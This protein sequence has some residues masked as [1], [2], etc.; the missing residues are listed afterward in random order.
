M[1]TQSEKASPLALRLP[2]T[3]GD[4]CTT[5]SI[6]SF[7]TFLTFACTIHSIKVLGYV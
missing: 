1:Q 2:I 6:I 3:G 7:R 5:G 4:G